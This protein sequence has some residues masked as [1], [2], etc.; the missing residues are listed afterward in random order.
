VSVPLLGAAGIMVAVTS[1]AGSGNDTSPGPGREE[2]P[3]AGPA[4]RRR[5]LAVLRVPG[6]RRLFLAQTVNLL[7]SAIAPIALAFA[8]L[9]QPGGSA[10][11][12]GLILAARALGQVT[13]LLF[14]GVLADRMPRLRLMTGSNLIAFA[15]QGSVAGLFLAGPA[16]LAAV[17]GLAAVNG[18]A[19]ALFLPA[20]RGVVPQ[21]APSG[22]LQPA[23]ALLRLSRNTASIAGAAL[24]GVLLA[25]TAPGWALACD[26]ASFVISAALLARIGRPSQ[27]RAG[28]ATGSGA[29]PRPRP[30]PATT[31]ATAAPSGTSTA[32]DPAGTPAPAATPSILADLRAGWREFRSRA[33]VW[34][35]VAQFTMVNGCFAAIWVLGPV[36]ARRDLGGAPAWAA[37]LTANA[38]G[39]VGGS[40]LALRLRPRH[41]LRLACAATFGFLPPFFLLAVSAPV[42]LIAA[43]MLINGVCVDIFEVLWDTALQRHV[44]PGLLSRITSYDLL[45]SFALGPLGLALAGPAAAAA[46]LAATLTGA[47][48]LLAAASVVPLLSRAVRDLPAEPVP[49]TVGSSAG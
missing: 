15:A 29:G 7:G 49:G 8:V 14:G 4:G 22:D 17:A 1:P 33:W 25:V 27:R 18:A 45:G 12:L 21:L 3:P 16:P 48:L 42:P 20:A 26:A 23:N 47:G 38:I 30:R 41:P 39:L 9:G 10:T 43:S 19:A 36:I 34:L 6:F 2:A 35:P 11:H 40:L 24:A 32:E 37:V 44:P 31:S 5:D 46:G 13:F 28:L